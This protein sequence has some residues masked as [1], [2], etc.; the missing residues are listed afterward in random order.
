MVVRYIVRA[1][2]HASTVNVFEQSILKGVRTCDALPSKS[3][4]KLLATATGLTGATARGLA[5]STG[6]GTSDL[7]SEKTRPA[8]TRVTAAMPTASF[9]LAGMPLTL[10]LLCVPTSLRGSVSTL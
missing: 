4:A 5:T 9:V 7:R 3:R 6:G 1:C 2:T 10:D 8:L